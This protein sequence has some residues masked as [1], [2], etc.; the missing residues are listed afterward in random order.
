MPDPVFLSYVGAVTGVIGSVLGYV[1][2]RQSVE[3]KAVDLRLQLGQAENELR[4][5]VEH[6]PALMAGAKQ[7]R[8]NVNAM[9]GQAGAQQGWL[10]SY[11]TDSEAAASLTAQ[12][13]SD[14]ESYEELK[15]AALARKVVTLHRLGL[16]AARLTDKY[17][18][19]LVEDDRA[20]EERRADIRARGA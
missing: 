15:P 10:N 12:L 6:L 13:P 3:M 19:S 4:I 18:A 2:Y 14:E 11:S 5:S 7:S 17:N 1:G 8:T 20:R 9:V 16:Q